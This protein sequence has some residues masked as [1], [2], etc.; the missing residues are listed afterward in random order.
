MSWKEKPGGSMSIW[1]LRPPSAKS[2]L[3]SRKRMARN[4]SYLRSAKG[5][6]QL[7]QR[8][9]RR[10]AAAASRAR[11]TT[12]SKLK[13]A[14]R[15]LLGGGGARRATRSRAPRKPARA[16][17][18]KRAAVHASSPARGTSGAARFTAPGAA[19]QGAAGA[20]ARLVR[21]APGA[22]ATK[23]TA[24]GPT[25]IRP[26]RR[27]LPARGRRARRQVE[28][29]LVPAAVEEDGQPAVAAAPSTMASAA[30]RAASQSASGLRLAG[31]GEPGDVRDAVR[32]RRAGEQRRVGERGVGAAERGEG[33]DV[34]LERAVAAVP[35]EPG[36][37]RCP[38][39]RRCC[40]RA[41]VRP[42]SSPAVSMIVPREAKSVAS[43]ARRSRRA[44]GDDGGVVGRRPRRRCS[45]SG[46]RRGRRGC[47]RR[48]PRCAC[49]GRRRGRR[50]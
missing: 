25:V 20:L 36:D 35:V 30:A 9:A 3:S 10:A 43:S 38:G 22:S 16:A 46:C 31:G 17:C 29:D 7:H 13:G 14:G 27:A 5:S 50:G 19:A 34:G 37:R 15:R 49:G 12:A 18:R 32:A 42:N 6:A 8:P 21:T 40:C 1:K 11:A 45:R 2:R 23:A 26:P 47:P 41:G 24:R 33:G 39:H 28:G 4:W 48:W 44:R